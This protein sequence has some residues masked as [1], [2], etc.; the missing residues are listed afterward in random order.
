MLKSSG[1]E[2]EILDRDQIRS[3]IV[4]RLGLDIGALAPLDRHVEGIVDMIIV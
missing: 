3:S 1:I 2:G 4:R